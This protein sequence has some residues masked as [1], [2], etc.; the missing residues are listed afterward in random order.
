[1]KYKNYILLALVLISLVLLV[2]FS[3]NT[4]DTNTSSQP[5]PVTSDSSQETVEL[6]QEQNQNEENVVS[7]PDQ[8][9]PAT[10]PAAITPP[11]SPTQ[12]FTA[13]QPQT[14]TTTTITPTPPQPLTALESAIQGDGSQ[15]CI[16]VDRDSGADEIALIKDGVIRLQTR[17]SS[18]DVYYTLYSSLATYTWKEGE[19]SGVILVDDTH[20]IASKVLYETRDEIG[21]Y[22]T[23]NTRVK[24]DSTSLSD[25][26][27]TPPSDV[28]FVRLDV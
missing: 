17:E 26:H 6:T 18:G 2:V 5:E 13:P 23:Q 11:T 9:T 15:R 10:P 12:T 7:E 19:K 3:S 24:C 21:E 8:A 14:P 4:T 27:F 22:I 25:S 1:M 16:W 28:S 20:P